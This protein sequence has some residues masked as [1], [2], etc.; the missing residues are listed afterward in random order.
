MNVCMITRSMP[1]QSRGG[2]QDHTHELALGLSRRGHRVIVLTTAHAQGR[3]EDTFEN[4]RV[5]Y[6]P[7]TRLSVLDSA[8]WDASRQA[9]RDLLRKEHIDILHSQG[10][11]GYSIVRENG[12]EKSVPTLISFHG[13]HYD[14]LVTRWKRGF[15]FNPVRSAK[16][17]AAIGIVLKKFYLWDKRA[18]RFADAFIATSN[19]QE[20]LLENVYHLPAEKIHKVF[21]GMDLTTFSP[22][23]PAATL[24]NRLNV[25]GNALIVLCMARLIR[26]KGIQHMIAAMPRI[27][28]SV[29]Q[30]RLIVVGDGNYRP[31]LERLVRA[32]HLE[33]HIIFAGSVEFASLPDYFRLADIFVN[34]TVQ[35]NG[36][37]LTMVEAMA[38]EKTVISSHIGSTP[39]LIEHNREG[40]LFPPAN[41]N[42]LARS[43]V[44]LLQDPDRRVLMGRQGR[45][46][47]LRD[48][49]LDTM[50]EKTIGVYRAL[51]ERGRR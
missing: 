35:Q 4:V 49:T 20:L 12:Q 23:E 30:S 24:R 47:V 41:S 10:P 8:W 6:L 22:G 17:L 45:K 28:Q 48:F 11:A 27:L 34:P 32:R 37:D 16:N 46:K 38:C 21:N 18:M 2:V 19:E 36:Y 5:C 40:I 3:A 42:L 50:V 43:V 13:T 25:P 51:L 26:D 7:G 15:S 14:E 39:T 33:N 31:S 29:P 1:S 9:A 44:E